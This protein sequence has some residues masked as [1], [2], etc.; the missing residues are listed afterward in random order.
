MRDEVRKI[1]RRM[2][3]TVGRDRETLRSKRTADGNV[4]F[5]I[6]GRDVLTWTEPV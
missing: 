4:S 6:R 1:K 5:Q 2:N 3:T